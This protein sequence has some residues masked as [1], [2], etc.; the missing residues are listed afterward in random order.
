MTTSNVLDVG[1]ETPVGTGPETRSEQRPSMAVLTD[2]FGPK[3]SP[4][5]G[6]NNRLLLGFGHLQDARA[7][8]IRI[9][10]QPALEEDD[11][12]SCIAG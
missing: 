7:L 10:E 11:L 2:S 5:L 4:R 8:E 3:E 6:R 12:A 9:S 1:A